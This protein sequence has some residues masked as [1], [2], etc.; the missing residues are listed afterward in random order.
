LPAASGPSPEQ[1]P[2]TTFFKTSTRNLQQAGERAGIRR[3][4]VVSII[5]TD[6]F[7]AGYGAAKLVHEQANDGRPHSDT[8][9]ARRTVP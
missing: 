8:H 9:P 5:G 6:R 7:T 1:E 4:V 3:I 2:A